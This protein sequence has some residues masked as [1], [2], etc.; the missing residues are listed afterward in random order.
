MV[1]LK[2][3][4]AA[5][6]ILVAGAGLAQ[7]Q[8]PERPITLIVPFAAGGGTDA[9]ARIVAEH[10]TRTLKQSVTV[11]NVGGAGGAIAVRRLAQSPPDGYTLMI[12][13]MGTHAAA[14]SIYANL[15]Y[16]PVAD[17]TAIGLTAGVPTVLVI[18]KDFPAGTL[19][20]F[21]DFVKR[22]EKTVNEAHAGVG[23]SAHLTCT[24]L[25]SIMGT[26]TG[27]VAYRGLGPGLN[28]MMSGQID[29]TCASL[30]GVVSHIQAGSVRALAIAGP[31]RVDLVADVPTAREGGLPEFDAPNWN[32]IFAPR[33]LPVVLVA[34]LNDAIGKALDDERTRKRLL[35]LGSEIPDRTERTPQFLHT[36]VKAEVTH[37]SMVLKAAGVAP[38]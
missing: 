33:N 23:G 34:T 36:F 12:G 19:R 31:K 25:Q 30:S 1:G 9:I 26:M 4:I 28:D 3:L 6:W 17:F 5:S 20:Q 27:R 18:R 16:D 37:W 10:M 15:K 7:A 35:D 11:E 2:R 14:P 21:V 8:Y 38:N 22:N 13:N 24:L 32:A 29:F